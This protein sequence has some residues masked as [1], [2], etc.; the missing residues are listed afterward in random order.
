M[1]IDIMVPQLPSD[2]ECRLVIG[3]LRAEI[4]RILDED[5]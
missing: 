2:D 4:A 1:M 3:Y 5:P